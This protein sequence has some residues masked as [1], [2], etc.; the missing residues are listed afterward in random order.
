MI[1][2]VSVGR[3]DA[4]VYADADVD[5]DVCEWLWCVCVSW[6]GSIA[7]LGLCFDRFSIVTST[8]YGTTHP[9]FMFYRLFIFPICPEF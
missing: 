2:G 6:C 7:F 8:S 4:D 9:A 1:H 3:R 5:V